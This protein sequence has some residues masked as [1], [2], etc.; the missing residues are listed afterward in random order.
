MTRRS[1]LLAV[2]TALGLLL[3]LQIGLPASAQASPT[4]TSAAA[5]TKTATPIKHFVTL[6][7]ENHSFDNYFGTYPGADGFPKGTCMPVKPDRKR[8]RCV[9]P[10]R[11]T[12]RPIVDLGHTGQIHKAQYAN[13]KMNGFISAFAG[14]RG[15]SILPMGYYDD[16][17]LPYYWNIADNYVLFDRAFTSAA[18]GS[19]WNHFYW[20]SGAPGNTKADALL[21][22]GFD[23][24]PTIFDRL[25]AAG[26]DWKFYIQNY[27]PSVSFRN[28]GSGDRASQIIWAP[29]LNYNRFL[30]D[31]ELR[32]H[33]V[34]MEQ[35]FTDLRNNQLPAVSYLVPSGASEHPPGSIQAGSRFVRGLVNALMASSA[36]DSSAFMWTYDDWGGWYDH[37]KPPRVDGYGY[38]FRAPAL[39][40][41]P[42]AK[43]G[44]VNHTTIDFTSQ[45]KFIEN[46]WRVK[47]LTKRDSAA[48]D[49]SSA[50]NFAAPPREAIVLSEQRHVLKP[51]QP[52]TGI[53]YTLYGAALAVPGLVLGWSW[54]LPRLRWRGL[55]R[56]KL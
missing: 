37:V 4:D 54:L 26:V 31:P 9:E 51:P 19:V 24:V 36:W 27:D 52:A 48:N 35:Y 1:R 15:A 6:M 42:Y 56:G 2:W 29:I 17:D 5:K 53:V 25:Q 40:V 34:P 30:D 13:G 32:S 20:V 16:R 47:P 11:V 3:A 33:I 41:S 50:F 43:K 18:G 38:G 49:I 12:G 44:E 55:R 39:L 14:Q 7:Q 23:H 46:N 10:F 21:T 45:L 28:P 8:G 22:T